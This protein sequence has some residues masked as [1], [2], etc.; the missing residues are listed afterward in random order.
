MSAVVNL[1]YKYI[2]IKSRPIWGGCVCIF[3]TEFQKLV[4]IPPKLWIR[5]KF[6]LNFSKWRIFFNSS[7]FLWKLSVFNKIRWICAPIKKNPFLSESSSK[8]DASNGK[9]IFCSSKGS[10]DIH[11]KQ[12]LNKQLDSYFWESL[13]QKCLFYDESCYEFDNQS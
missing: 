6:F 1:F 3:Y 7:L 11:P 4:N 5:E 12:S 9:K 2:T 8:S 10:G 13:Y